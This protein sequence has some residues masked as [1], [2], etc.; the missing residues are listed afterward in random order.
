G[1]PVAIGLAWALELTPRGVML[2]TRTM[3]RRHN[4]LMLAAVLLAFGIGAF[5]LIDAGDE[6]AAGAGADEEMAIAAA[7]SNSIAVIPFISIG[8]DVQNAAFAD[9]LAEELLNLLAQLDEL[10]VA[11]RTSSFYFKNKDI[12]VAEMSARLGV[13]HILGGTVRRN[14]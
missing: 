5:Y 9:G 11:A 10:K 7:Q 4:L 14:G 8:T 3:G 13:N 6:T 2:D 12:E 1:F